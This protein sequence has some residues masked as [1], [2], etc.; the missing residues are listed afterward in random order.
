LAEL[1]E[2]RATDGLLTTTAYE[3]FNGVP[4]AIAKRAEDIFDELD[5]DIQ[6]SLGHVFRDLVDV[7]EQGV[8]TRRRTPLNQL[9]SSKSAAKLVNALTDARLLVTSRGESK[10]ST[11]EV[12]HEAL[13]RSW[14]RLRTWID[15]TADDLRLQRQIVQLADYWNTHE[16]RDEHRWSD[17]RVKEVVEMLDHLALKAGDLPELQQEF[18][19]PLDRDNM[20]AAL[21][22]PATSHETR[23]IIGVR[24]SLL[25]DPRLGV[26]LCSDG[27]PDIAW[28]EVPGGKIVLE[29]EAGTFRVEPFYIA[30]YPVTYVQYRAFLEADDG[31]H[32][33]DWWQGLPF[34]MPD[35]PGRQANR[36]NNHP[37]ENVAWYESV[38]FCRW[39][40]AKLGYAIQLP[41][42]WEWQQAATGG[43]RDCEYPWPGNW[44]PNLA[45]TDES[46]LGRSTAVGMYPRG[47]S[48][49]GALDMAGNVY[50]LC[51]NKYENASQTDLSGN[52]RRVVRGGAWLNSQAYARAAYRN[53]I[54]PDNRNNNVGF[55]LSC[56]AHIFAPPFN[57]AGLL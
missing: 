18:L 8:A 42:E 34:E 24:L 32:N 45:N 14:P 55:R 30:K 51:R 54:H 41:T 2:A 31:F 21:D 35:K 56:L 16:R 43:D 13:L 10:I 46:E 12:A 6:A 11:V 40:S 52:A 1:Y 28:C 5:K 26:G 4:G 37:A 49:V 50:E 17:D 36:R 33:Q 19:G 9:S 29:E 47:A 48:P 20:L 57:G 27:L 25:G 53:N 22:D 44:D 38:A 39:L 23:A 15:T 7:D 3:E